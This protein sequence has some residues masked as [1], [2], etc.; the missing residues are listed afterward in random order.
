VNSSPRS[1][2]LTSTGRRSNV[3]LPAFAAGALLLVV[4]LVGVSGGEGGGASGI[5][6]PATSEPEV[7]PADTAQTQDSVDLARYLPLSR[8]LSSGMVGE[9][10]VLLQERLM[11]LGFQPGGSDGLYASLTTQA[12]WAFEKLVMGVP[13]AEVTGRVTPEM[14]DM[15]RSPMR[16]VPRR[17]RVA[18]TNHVE[19]Y[20]PEQV[21]AVFH[22]GRAV[23]VA[24]AS[25]GT[26]EDWCK[27]VTISPGE[28]GNERGTEPRLVGRCGRS[29][30]PGGVFTIHRKVEGHRQSSLG[31]LLNPVYFNYGIAV[32]GGFEVP[33]EPASHGCVRVA[34][35]ISPQFFALTDF[36]DKV[37]VW[38]GLKEPEQ[39]GEQLP[40]FDRADPNYVPS[41]TEPEEEEDLPILEMPTTTTSST[42]ASS[43]TTTTSTTTSTTASTTTTTTTL[44]AGAS[45]STTPDND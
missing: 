25:S 6:V 29:T 45:S 16:I 23:F 32:H 4:V 19:I 12:V 38:D 24:H 26:G 40:Y 22:A 44:P 21:V 15:M 33:L 9:D 5:T 18:S 7:A 20:L 36:G 39:Y 10:V 8:T 11:E 42:I 35:A 17:S 30:T 1:S 27:E 13:R 3:W 14:W 34:N 37:F 28:Y 41:T 43:T 2:P 31:G